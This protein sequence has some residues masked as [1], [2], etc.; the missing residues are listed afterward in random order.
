[1]Q[2]ICHSTW[3]VAHAQ[4]VTASVLRKRKLGIDWRGVPIPKFEEPSKTSLLGSPSLLSDLLTKL[5]E[6]EWK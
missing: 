5:A 1:M 3:Q 2:I 4:T 6:G